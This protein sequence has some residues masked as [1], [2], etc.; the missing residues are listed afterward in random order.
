MAV[1]GGVGWVAVGCGRRVVRRAQS[2][3]PP[4]PDCSL[5]GIRPADAWERQ[6]VTASTLARTPAGAAMAMTPRAKCGLGRC[7]VLN[8]YRVR[9]C[10]LFEAG[11][12]R[13]R[14]RWKFIFLLR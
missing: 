1:C 10:N 13:G 14:L 12:A 4:T 2:L 11:Q 9:V 5:A 8:K 3:P 7:C 6:C